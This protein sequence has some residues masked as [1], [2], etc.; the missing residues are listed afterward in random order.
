M[1]M[2]NNLQ[3]WSPFRELDLFKGGFD[4]M[5]DRFFGGWSPMER[6]AMSPALESYIDGG[7]LVIRADLPGIDPKDVEVTVS[8]DVLTVRGKREQTHEEKNRNYLHREVSYGSFERSITL[9][10][11][12]DADQIKAS[13]KNGVLELTMPAPK[14]MAPRKVAIEVAN[15]TGETKALNAEKRA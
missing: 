9:P 12:V 1:T 6:S 11:G 15:G 14:E 2:A 8:G 7:N 3:V 4:E 5:L 10:E 13:F